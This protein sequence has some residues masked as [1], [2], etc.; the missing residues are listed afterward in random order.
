MTSVPR[1]VANCVSADRALAFMR[2]ARP[3]PSDPT[4]Y[5]R[6]GWEFWRSSLFEQ[7]QNCEPVP[8][9]AEKAMMVLQQSVMP[10]LDLNGP[11]IA[12]WRSGE[13]W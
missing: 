4:F 3:S 2:S 7:G 6:L 10:Q 8:F 9:S 5:A 13:I 1:F 11:L 12:L